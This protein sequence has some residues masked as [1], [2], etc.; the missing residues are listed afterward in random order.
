MP[1]FYENPKIF[2]ILHL[3]HDPDYGQMRWTLDTKEDLAMLR[4]VAEYFEGQDDFSWLDVL[5]LMGKR[6]EI[7]EI[8]MGVRHKDYREVDERK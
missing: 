1:Y 7:Q 8:N 6:T 3:K 5:D 4:R 2:N